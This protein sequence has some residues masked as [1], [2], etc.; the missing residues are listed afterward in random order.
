[1]DKGQD[2]GRKL[3]SH[4]LPA[5]MCPGHVD[6][7]CATDTMSIGISLSPQR[8]LWALAQEQGPRGVPQRP[9]PHHLYPGGRE[10][11]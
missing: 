9:S 1:M 7:D 11:E 6:G 2:L 10:P 3:P 8:P 5:L 4:L